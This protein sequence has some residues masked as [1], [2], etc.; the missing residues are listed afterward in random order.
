MPSMY[1]IAERKVKVVVAAE[2]ETSRDV[3]LGGNSNM[4]K[5]DVMA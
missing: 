1:N 5:Q 2:D 3:V 4:F